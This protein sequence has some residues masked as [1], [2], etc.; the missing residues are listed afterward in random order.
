[1]TNVT[2]TSEFVTDTMALILRI[3]RRKL[4][5]MA[6][7]IFD[8]VEAGNATVYIPAMVFAEILY[9]SEKQ[10]ISISLYDVAD[11]LKQ[12]PNYKEYP[13]SFA[14]IQS[15]AQITDIGE[16]HD[17]LIAGTAQLLNLDLITNDPIIQASAFV[18]TIW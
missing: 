15:T 16:L 13:M 3:E 10:K 11:Y 5:P 8:S 14:V 18:K 1:M 17:R 9:L 7:S 4:E 6:K 12:Y 2:P